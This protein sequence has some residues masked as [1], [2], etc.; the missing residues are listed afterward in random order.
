MVWQKN[1][2]AKRTPFFLYILCCY[3]VSTR[4]SV[5]EKERRLSQL[6]SYKF[7]SKAAEGAPERLPGEDPPAPARAINTEEDL[8]LLLRV[9]E[10]QGRYSEALE[11]LEDPRTGLTSDYSKNSWELARQIIRFHEL[12]EQWEGLW[13]TCQ[14]ILERVPPQFSKPSTPATRFNF[15]L[16]GDDW[17]V[18]DGLVTGCERLLRLMPKEKGR[19]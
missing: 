13:L 10:S 19:R 9:F 14:E 1:M 15:G 7:L 17:L 8:Y 11:R 18:W 4:G 5:D 12:D 6:L 16:L 3:L 2:P